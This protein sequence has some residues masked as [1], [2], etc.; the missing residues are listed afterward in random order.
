[1]FY[2]CSY[3]KVPIYWLVAHKPF[4]YGHSVWKKWAIE[5]PTIW[6]TALALIET[7]HNKLAGAST[8]TPDQHAP[9]DHSLGA[10][11]WQV[12][13]TN[14]IDLHASLACWCSFYFCA[15]PIWIL[16]LCKKLSVSVQFIILMQM[17]GQLKFSSEE[18]FKWFVH[19]YL[20]YYVSC[21][22]I[23]VFC[24]PRSFW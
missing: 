18:F 2:V 1:M 4:F 10:A 21:H 14:L 17:I 6:L 3:R 19:I 24:S 11:L 23:C 7:S 15:G 9:L 8:W 13:S 20:L 12:P 22:P 16:L 5:N